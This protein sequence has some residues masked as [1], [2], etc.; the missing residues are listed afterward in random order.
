M[1]IRGRKFWQWCP[2]ALQPVVR[3]LG[4]EVVRLRYAIAD[5]LLAARTTLGHAIVHVHGPPHISTRAD[6]VLVLCL[7]RNGMA[8]L[9][10]FLRHYRALGVR[11]IVL[12]DNG[13]TDATVQTAAGY[14]DVT[15]YK[16]LLPFGRYETAFKRWLVR[17]FAAECWA[18]VADMDELFDF[19]FAQTIGLKGL[20]AYLDR[21]GYDAVVAQNLEMVPQQPL[22]DYQG[23]THNDLEKTHRFYDLSDYRKTADASWLTMNKL[24][25]HDLW[26]HTGGIWETFFGY[27]GSKL[28]KQPLLRA[29]SGLC[30]FPY[31]VHF[32]TNAHIADVTALFR[33][34]KYTGMFV[35]HVAEELTRRQHYNKAEIFT[36][37]DRVLREN[38]SISFVRPTSRIFRAAEELLESGFL[39]ASEQYLTWVSS[40]DA[41]GNGLEVC[42]G[43]SNAR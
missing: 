16:S 25:G 3:R 24:G 26:S 43:S 34:Y 23:I 15:V 6:D 42:S 1:L 5:V 9:P 11:H 35:R 31:D 8:H 13:S 40:Y 38:P 4:L 20:I 29:R 22:L 28:T 33:H 18:I 21:Y 39:V 37:Y 17:T 7:V 41:R 30:V 14:D 2:T 12:L 10:T 32:V 19:P 27:R 36:H